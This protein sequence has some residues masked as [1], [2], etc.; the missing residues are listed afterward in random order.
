MTRWLPF[1]R[2]T[3][4]LLAIWLLLNESV[5]P[6][7][8]LLGAILA[9]GASR[10]LAML[11]L[12]RPAVLRLRPAIGLGLVVL[13]DVV[14]SNLAVARIILSPRA[15][16]SASGFL[17]IPLDMRSPFGLASLA[18]IITATPGTIWVAYDSRSNTVLLH[19][20]DLAD[21]EQW[22]RTIKDRYERRL[23]EVFE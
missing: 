15:R 11:D 16:T 5:S 21:E 18:C 12:P 4:A 1:P 13:L 8:V 14:R 2:L 19:I 23:M 7:T 10:T 17:P 6:G 3:A 22:V 9:I 20:L